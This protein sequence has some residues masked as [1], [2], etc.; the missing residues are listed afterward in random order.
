VSSDPDPAPSRPP[1]DP[2]P[3][4]KPAR[5]ALRVKDMV[6]AIGVLLVVV[7]VI[8]GLSRGFSFAPGGPTV[9]PTGIPVVDAPAE[10]RGLASSVPFALRVPAVPPGWRSNSV[11][12]DRVVGTDRTDVRIGYLT[13]QS[14]YLQLLQTDAAED[15]LLAA[16]QGAARLAAQGPQDVGGQEWVVYGTQPSEPIWI[17][18][19]ATPGGGSVRMLI[20]GS[21]TVDDYRALAGAVV[22]GE[23]LK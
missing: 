19:V 2:P 16:Q 8:G 9:D 18:D 4:A 1:A 11:A 14:Q 7:L 13:E 3:M 17:A 20:S 6:V 10:L 12:E 15:A 22:A 23:L 21:G 5:G